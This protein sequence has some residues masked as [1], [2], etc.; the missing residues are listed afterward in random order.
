MH[1]ETRI[2]RDSFG[3]ISVPANSYGGAQTARSMHHF[4]IGREKMPPEMI[5]AFGILKKAAAMANRDLK[6]LPSELCSYIVQAADEVIDGK[7]DQHFPLNI[8]Q[9]GSGT[10]SNMNANEVISNRAITL[11]GGSMGSKSPIHPNDHVN[12]AQSTNDVFHSAMHI[13]AYTEIT[14]NLLPTLQQLQKA[15]EKK[16]HQWKKVIKTGRT[17]LKDAVPMTLGQ[18]FSGYA[19]M[20]VKNYKHIKEDTETLREINLGGTAIGTGINTSKN[21]KK[22]VY[23]ALAQSTRIKLKPTVNFFEGTASLGPIA[24]AHA[25]LKVLAENLIKIANDLRLLSSGPL[26]G[27]NEITLP[28]IQPG[29]SIMPAKVNPAIAEML[30]MVCFQVL[31][32]DTTIGL[33]SQA[34]QLE[35][36]VMMPLAAYTLLNS[37]HILSNSMHT[38]TERCVKGIKANEQ[39]CKEYVEKNPILVTALTP[40]IGYQKAAD[41][42]KRA[43]HE[44]RSVKDIVREEKLMDLKV[45]EKILNIKKLIK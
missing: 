25:P 36:N 44:E 7:L 1:P 16:A 14:K 13:A 5:R 38:F 32:N 39:K 28:A 9:T 22:Y 11:A 29:S 23:Q 6:A 2:E 8:W 12:L 30:D 27:F 34:G 45:L 18:E 3:E 24:T 17:H 20:L 26:G 19:A 43:Y 10:Q 4:A 33:C 40:Y 41:V 21:Y 42:A 37:I 15:L 31:G 35:L